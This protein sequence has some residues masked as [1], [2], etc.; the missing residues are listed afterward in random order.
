MQKVSGVFCPKK[1][2]FK[3]QRPSQ[4]HA[5]R[6]FLLN[7]QQQVVDGSIESG[8][9]PETTCCSLAD[10]ILTENSHQRLSAEQ[11]GC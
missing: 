4:C 11:F 5:N 1:N 8:M 10:P 7:L 2:T 3:L 6:V 9:E